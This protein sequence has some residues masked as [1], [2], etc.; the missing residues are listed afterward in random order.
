VVYFISD[1]LGYQENELRAITFAALIM[2]NVVLILS[3]L[4]KT[5]SFIAVILENNIATTTMISFALIMTA[6]ILFVPTLQELFKVQAPNVKGFIAPIVGA[7]SL[8]ALF[9]LAKFITQ[10]KQVN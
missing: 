8:L 2:G 3:N 10:T 1:H 9:E 7:T 6:L 5:R 4:S